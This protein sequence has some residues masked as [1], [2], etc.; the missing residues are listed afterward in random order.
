MRIDSLSGDGP[1]SWII[2]WN[3]LNKF[4]RD[5]TEKTRTLGDNENNAAGTR[6]LVAEESRIVKFSRTRA[7]ENAAKAKP[8]PNSSPLSLHPLRRVFQ[9]PKEFGLI[10]NQE[11]TSVRILKAFRIQRGCLHCSDTKLFLD[12]KMEQFNFGG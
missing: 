6:Q 4:V 10:L 8:K 11:S 12:T 1:Q 9:F 3:E 2:I 5:L 7:D